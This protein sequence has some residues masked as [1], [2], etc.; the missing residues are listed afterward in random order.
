MDFEEG[1]EI[2]LSPC[3]HAFTKGALEK[4]LE[5]EKPECPICRYQFD[6]KEVRIK[7]KESRI[8]EITEPEGEGNENEENTENEIIEDNELTNMR[9]S[10]ATLF[11]SLARTHP[12]G[13]NQLENTV[14]HSYLANMISERG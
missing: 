11:D 7:K 6:Y 2:T 14:P 9:T 8:E 1:Q 10:R 4:W 13:R 5:K 12:F 3:N